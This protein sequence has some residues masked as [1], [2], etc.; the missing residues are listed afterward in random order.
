MANEKK[1]SGRPVA[2]TLRISIPNVTN[3]GVAMLLIRVNE[4]IADLEGAT[5]DLSIAPPRPER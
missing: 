3:E 1:E 5:Y 4:F 2:V